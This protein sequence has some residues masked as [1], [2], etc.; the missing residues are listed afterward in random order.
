VIKTTQASRVTARL[1]YLGEVPG[2]CQ[3]GINSS[4]LLSKQGKQ[5]STGVLRSAGQ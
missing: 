4:R 1:G 3:A 2:G 5:G